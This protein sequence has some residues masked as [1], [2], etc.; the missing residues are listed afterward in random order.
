MRRVAWPLLVAGLLVTSG[1]ALRIAAALRPGLWADEIFSLSMAT[2]HSLEHPAAAA[3]PS[4]GDFAEPRESQSPTFFGRYTQHEE[5]PVGPW[6][7]VRAV[8]LSDTSPPLYYLLLNSWT[9]IFGTGDAALRLF[10]VWW[11]LLSLPLLWLLGRELGGGRVA[12]YA[13]L[14]FSFAPVALFYSVEGRM[15]SLLWFLAL[16][17]SWLTLQLTTR[18]ERS[19]A[20]PMWVLAGVSGLFTHYFFAFVW[21][22]CLAWLWLDGRVVRRRLVVLAGVTMLAV[23]PWYL[24][25]PTSLARW[26]VTGAW[27]NGDLEWPQ[28]LGKPFVLAGTLLSGTTYLGGSQRADRLIGLLF[29]LLVIWIARR[30]SVRSMASDRALLLWGWLAAACLGPLLFDVLRHTTTTDIPRYALPGLPAA[31]LLAALGISQLPRKIS[32]AFVGAILLAWV[33]GGRATLSKVPR[34]WEPYQKVAATLESWAGPDDLVL[35][36][37]VPSGVIGFSRYLRPDI[38]IVSWV[39][40]LST[41]VVPDDLE[42]LLEGRRRVALVRI[43]DA[44]AS[45]PAEPW[46][47]THGQLLGRRT[48]RRSSAEVL[49]FGPPAGATVFRPAATIVHRSTE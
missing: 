1:M 9:R 26:R 28:A 40:Q 2:G 42:P 5:S 23:L 6:R 43:H 10:S 21:L 45:P 33:P 46:L 37:S 4:L 18:R 48:F 20:A 12:W 32:L 39:P 49:Y 13:C 15:Y 19:W 29:V 36:S 44:G 3:D 27:L 8:L 47:R 7:I 17:L 25:V 41:R 14:L 35:V 34:P 30:G 24:E 31:I 22:A 38:R 16:S 11:A